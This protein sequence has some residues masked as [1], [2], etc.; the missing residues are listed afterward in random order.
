VNYCKTR[1][2]HLLP[3]G[4][5]L[6]ICAFSFGP[7][8]SARGAFISGF[9]TAPGAAESHTN[10]DITSFGLLVN[11]DSTTS[12]FTAVSSSDFGTLINNGNEPS[13]GTGDLSLSVLINPVT[14]APLSGSFS[15][16]GDAYGGNTGFL[17]TGSIQQF[18]FAHTATS[19][20]HFQ[21]IFGTTG[22][23]LAAY[24]PAIAVNMTLVN[25]TANGGT[26]TTSGT[27]AASFGDISGNAQTDTYVAAPEPCTLLLGVLGIFAGGIPY[28]K[29]RDEKNVL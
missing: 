20:E 15:I 21:F 13:T 10:P 27:F 16:T 7:C 9:P 3:V 2:L 11:Y 14:G 26:F 22:G 12:T 6:A 1:L 19:S 8:S 28:R 17:L 24:Y 29:F 25:L 5:F 4:C 18:G 23:D